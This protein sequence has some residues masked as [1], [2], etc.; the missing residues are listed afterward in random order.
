MYQ[1]GKAQRKRLVEAADRLFRIRGVDGASFSD[2]AQ[3]A[4]APRGNVHHYFKKKADLAVAVLTYRSALAAACIARWEG[5]SDVPLQR[6]TACIQDIIMTPREQGVFA[7]EATDR[8]GGSEQSGAFSLLRL[9]LTLQLAQQG[10]SAPELRARSLIAWV[11]GVV[12]AAEIFDDAEL[13]DV[14]C[15]AIKTWLERELG[16]CRDSQALLGVT[17]PECQPCSE[18]PIRSPEYRSPREPHRRER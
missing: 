7:G 13:R 12:S 9:W 18:V 15:A 2:I 3:E 4:G 6:V 5:Q 10:L 16:S 14:E 1:K 11:V 8:A 17:W